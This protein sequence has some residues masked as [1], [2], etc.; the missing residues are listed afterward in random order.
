MIVLLASLAVAACPDMDT[1]VERATA[2]LVS[3][4]FTTARS[5]LQA[6]E[7]SFGCAKAT[8]TQ[9]AHYWLVDGAEA[10]LKGEVARARASLA[11]ARVIAPDVFDDRLGP[12]VRATWTAAQPDGRGTLL[13][14]PPGAAL[15]NGDGV[16]V[17]PVTLPAANHVV[18]VLGSD[19]KV[20]YGRLIRIGPGEDAVVE[21]GLAREAASIVDTVVPVEKTAKKSPALLVLA[22]VAAAGAAGLAGGALAQ[23]PI[24]ETSTDVDALDAAFGRQQAFGYSSIALAGVSVVGLTLHFVIPAR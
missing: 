3:G 13:L 2:A 5:A 24:I 7:S 4:D 14:E 10:H 16:T 15:V 18:Q 17:W 22:G 11:A 8:N 12:D 9:L 6:A 19:G 1:E 23:G 21:T 20:R